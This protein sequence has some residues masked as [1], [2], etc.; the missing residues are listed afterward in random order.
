MKTRLV[1]SIGFISFI[2]LLASV[3]PVQADLSAQEDET[4]IIY[5]DPLTINVNSNGTIQVFHSKYEGHG[6]VFGDEFDGASGLFVAIEGDVFGHEVPA[7]RGAELIPMNEV[8]HTGTFGA[9]TEDDPFQ[10]ITVLELA[11]AGYGL[12]IEQ[13][14]S[15]IDG[16]DYFQL[17]WE[18][19][20]TGGEELGFK[21]YHGA[22]IYFALADEGFGYEANGA[23]GGYNRDE[24]WYMAFEPLTPADHFQED[25]FSTIWEIIGRGENLIDAVIEDREEDN[26]IALQWDIN[27]G[28]RG[29]ETVSDRWRFGDMPPMGGDVDIWV[30]DSPEDDG[31]VP[32]TRNN[33]AWW[34]SPDIVVRNEWD[35][36]KEHQNP[37]QD[38]ENYIYVNIRN[39]GVEDAEDVLVNVYYA[40]ANLL[41]PRWPDS[42]YFIDSVPMDIPAGEEVWTDA[43]PWTP[44]A[45]GHLCLFVRLESEQDPIQHEGNVPGDN[46]IAQ[47]NIHVIV[48]Q[49]GG[50]GSVSGSIDPILSNPST[51]PN[52]QIDLLLDYPG[53]IP[54]TMRVIVVLPEYLFEEWEANGGWVE[55]GEVIGAGEIELSGC[56]QIIIYNLPIAPLDEVQ[57]TIRFEGGAED[58]FT[59]GAIER[60]NGE[61]V[62]GNVYY[63][64]GLINGGNGNG[65]GV[66]KW[67]IDWLSDHCCLSIGILLGLLMLFG[68]II[69]LLTRKKK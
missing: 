61:D 20:N 9:G 55:G 68:L 29:S 12:R 41:S 42:F 34:T 52:T 40:D 59:L 60:V 65:D 39:R 67:I 48:M 58:Y 21:F 43:I 46:N 32:S 62:G 4:L 53:C 51:D 33:A 49:S 24:E 2:L 31:T 19:T 28:A 26:G 7:W 36:E 13:K 6:N 64:N 63:Y 66:F 37:I 8:G 25:I 11:D 47:R 30:K 56:G 17:D 18:F 10:I 44:P 15:Y 3:S 27:L 38:Q 1:L 54:D 23:V 69:F 22:D 5:G 50:S 35:D 45:S 57:I 14:V 16:K